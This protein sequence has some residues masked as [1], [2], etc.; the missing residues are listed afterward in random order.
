MWSLEYWYLKRH[1][2]RRKGHQET[3]KIIRCSCSSLAELLWFRDSFVSQF[4]WPESNPPHLGCN[5]VLL[6]LYFQWN[7]CLYWGTLNICWHPASL[8]HQGFLWLEQAELDSQSLGWGQQLQSQSLSVVLRGFSIYPGS[9]A[10][11]WRSGWT[12]ARWSCPSRLPFARSRGLKRR[13]DKI[14]RG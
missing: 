4:Q 8:C 9:R 12:R 1:L 6:H 5:S 11:R 10:R 3:P 7:P 13:W 2:G 14:C